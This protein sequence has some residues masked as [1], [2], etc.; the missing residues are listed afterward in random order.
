MINI[1]NEVKKTVI[2]LGAVDENDKPHYNA[3]GFLVQIRTVFHLVT[4]KHVVA[5]VKNGKFTEKLIDDSLIAFFNMK[6]NQIGAQPLKNMKEQFNVQWI[7]HPNESVDIAMIP[8]AL[9]PETY[10]LKVMPD[11]LFLGMERLYETYD[12]YFMSY[13]PGVNSRKIAPVIRRGMISLINGDNS[14]FMDGTAFPGNSGSP[15]FVKPSPIR[16]NE[17]GISVGGD[18]LG[19]KFIGVIGEYVPYQEVAVSLQT[20]RPRVMFEENTGLSKVWSVSF[21][22]EIMESEPFKKQLERLAPQKKEEPAG[23]PTGETSTQ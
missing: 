9:N 3:T 21:I 1:I 20:G 2:F 22:N 12:V 14:F 23:A 13:Q 6:N 19:G 11:N 16:F 17:N 8:I 15:V 18:D 10:D 4:A 7:F 5:E